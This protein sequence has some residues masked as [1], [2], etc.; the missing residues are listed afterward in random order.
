MSWGTASVIGLKFLH[1]RCIA[2]IL[3]LIVTNG[4]KEASKS[5]K[6]IREAIR[7][8]K[9]SP[10][11]LGN[12]KKSL[13]LLVFLVNLLSLLMFQQGKTQLI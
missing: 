7:Y 1:M 2:H 10:L 5:V 3:N 12:L 11:R 4:M 8:I 9:N 6:K 13:H